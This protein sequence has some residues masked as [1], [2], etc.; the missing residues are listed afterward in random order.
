MVLFTVTINQND[1]SIVSE[2]LPTAE[3]EHI[4]LYFS[5][6]VYNKNYIKKTYNIVQNEI[7]DVL[8]EILKTQRNLPEVVSKINGIFSILVYDKSSKT[9]IAVRDRSGFG[10]LSYK[11]NDDGSFTFSN[12]S[13]PVST[14]T[15]VVPVGNFLIFYN[16]DAVSL[17]NYND[18]EKQGKYWLNI[19]NRYL[20]SKHR[21]KFKAIA[22]SLE[23]LTTD[24]ILT[25]ADDIIRGTA[26][27]EKVDMFKFLQY[28]KL[29]A[30]CEYTK[31]YNLLTISLKSIVN[32]S[33]NNICVLLNDDVN[34]IALAVILKEL[35]VSFK[36]FSIH[37]EFSKI[38]VPYASTY[39]NTNH[40]VITYNTLIIRS[41][42]EE[43]FKTSEK[44]TI[45][46]ILPTYVF[47]KHLS[48][49]FENTNA[50][51]PTLADEIFGGGFNTT[52]I[53]PELASQLT[54]NRIISAS[55]IVV[56]ETRHCVQKFNIKA[57]YPYGDIHIIKYALFIN[58]S[59]VLYKG[60]LQSRMILK[61]A[62]ITPGLIEDTKLINIIF[63]DADVL[64]PIV[65]TL[66]S[67]IL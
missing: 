67:L 23:S 48:K 45:A 8:L 55:D 61:K 44:V 60:N 66:E 58:N 4:A 40:T 31:L 15:P 37:D 51:L 2:T 17:V 5:G 27:P 38:T 64:T 50:I 29:F 54:V 11:L 21:C 46:S 22:K 26:Y 7:D 53:T 32:V 49:T 33:D 19:R 65:R 3:C 28:A 14:T 34:T 13:T 47:C 56:P 10:A 25:F 35:K 41:E 1:N 63:S 30:I 43:M 18:Y 6:T 20:V 9:I 16:N 39:L 36:T 12:I 62:I 42:I 57:H 59:P 52:S 24:Q